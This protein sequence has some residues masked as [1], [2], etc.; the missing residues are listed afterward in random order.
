MKIL[1]IFGVVV[2]VH[3]AVF[4]FVFAIPGCRTTA[5]STPPPPASDTSSAPATVSY[6]GTAGSG[7]VAAAPGDASPS[8]NGADLNPGTADG[9]PTVSFNAGSASSAQHF[10]PTRPGTPVADVLQSGEVTGVTPASTYKVVSNDSLWKV[11]KKHGIGVDDLA[12]ANNLRPSSPLKVGQKLIIPG[13]PGASTSA[14]GA[15]SVASSTRTYTVKS[16]ESLGSIA[17]KQ[18]TTTAAIRALNPQMKNDTVRVGQDL[19]LPAASPSSTASTTSSSPAATASPVAAPAP[20]VAPL[21]SVEHIVKPGE[22]LSQIAKK[23]GVP[24]RE[25][26]ALNNIANPTS[27]R[28][29]QKIIIPGVKTPTP[30]PSTIP[31]VDLTPVT[32]SENPVAAAP[33]VDS[34]PVSAP[35]SDA[36]APPVVKVEESTPVAP[37]SK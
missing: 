36:P 14:G 21:G 27:L 10:N 5:R 6:P 32:P 11:A 29:G 2:A 8:L 25:I 17:R 20:V 13:K 26:A 33:S 19:T 16:G 18:G 37:A 7:P 31:P 28:A 23:Y 30:A 12:K 34:N 24:M 9:A 3:A 35:A 22:G 1:K 4:M 15:T